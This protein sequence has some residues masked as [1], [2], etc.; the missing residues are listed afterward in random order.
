MEVIEQYVQYLRSLQNILVYLNIE[1][2]A[3]IL[4]KM[5]ESV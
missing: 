4:Y 5:P 1:S 3:D 2:F